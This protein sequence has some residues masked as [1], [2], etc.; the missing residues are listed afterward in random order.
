[1]EIPNKA[2]AAS[3]INTWWM[4]LMINFARALVNR[5][6]PANLGERLLSPGRPL[7]YCVDVEFA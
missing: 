5:H 4:S 6:T 1:V 7:S 3:T 2:S